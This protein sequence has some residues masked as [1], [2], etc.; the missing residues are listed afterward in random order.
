MILLTVSDLTLAFAGQDILSGIGF[1]VHEG[2]RLGILGNNGVGKTSLMRAI[3]GQLSPARGEIHLAHGAT[4]G[5]LPQ[6]TAETNLSGRD[7]VLS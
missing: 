5:Y 1:A 3:A 2:D 4:V 6:N 7:S